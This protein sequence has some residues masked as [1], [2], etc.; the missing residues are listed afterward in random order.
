MSL[1]SEFFN[2]NPFL[3]ICRSFKIRIRI[4][5]AETTRVSN[6]ATTSLGL[7]LAWISGKKLAVLDF[8]CEVKNAG[9]DEVR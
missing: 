6:T 4:T 3:C 7:G 2:L 9:K 8:K 1:K 5:T